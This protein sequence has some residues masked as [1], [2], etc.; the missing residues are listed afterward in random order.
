[1]S[2]QPTETDLEMAEQLSKPDSDGEYEEG[3]DPA[4]SQC[5]CIGDW[6]CPDH[7]EALPSV[8]E[9][10]DNE[11]YWCNNDSRLCD[12]STRGD[13]DINHMM[14]TEVS[15]KEHKTSF[16]ELFGYW[17]K[18]EQKKKLNI[19]VKDSTKC[20]CKTPADIKYCCY[21]QTFTSFQLLSE[22]RTTTNKKNLES[23][24][25]KKE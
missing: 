6:K 12:C 22:R 17:P 9:V 4:L 2:Q 24:E 16:Y 11:C 21:Y 23:I 19:Y 7:R 8:Q 25:K 13:G 5:E 10:W 18:D 15:Y 1:M 14:S 20:K 3:W